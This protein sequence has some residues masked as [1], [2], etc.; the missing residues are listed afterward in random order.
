MFRLLLL[1]LFFLPLTLLR[2]LPMA[3]SGCT[4]AAVGTT[5]APLAGSSNA[6]AQKP[7][8]QRLPQEKRSKKASSADDLRKI[9]GIGPKI[10]STLQAAGIY[11]FADLAISTPEAVSQILDDAGIRIGFPA[12]WPE[13]AGLAA[14]GKWDELEALQAKLKGGRRV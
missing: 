8:P 1:S 6:A 9:E 10:A 13:Q 5:V 11:S 12:T 2:W 14:S 7:S 3:F 4:R